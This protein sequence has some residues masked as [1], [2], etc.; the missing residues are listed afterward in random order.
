VRLKYQLGYDDSLDVVGVHLVGGVLGTLLIG[1]LA[2]PAAPNGRTGLIYGGGFGLLGVQALAVVAVLAYSFAITWLIAT[3]VERTIGLRLSRE[4][5]A[6]G[7]D[8]VLHGERAYDLDG[9][10]HAPVA[11]IAAREQEVVASAEAVITTD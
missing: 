8:I 6:E 3:V 5:E 11:G 7:V 2:D 1:L 4:V 10:V 9:H